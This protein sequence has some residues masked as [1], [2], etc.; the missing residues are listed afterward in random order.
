MPQAATL[1]ADATAAVLPFAPLMEAIAEVVQEVEAGRVTVPER[2]AHPLPGGG[3]LL[4]MPAADSRLLVVKVV[5][6]MPENRERGLPTIQGDFLV[7]DVRT[8]AALLTLD[9]ATVTNRRTAALTLLG[10]RAVGVTAA[11]SVL[12]IGAGPQARAHAEAFMEVLGV[13]RFLVASRRPGSAEKLAAELRAAGVDASRAPA[14]RAA[15]HD[16]DLVLAATTSAMPVVPDEVPD[17]VFVAAVGAFRRGMAEL[18]AALLRRR[19]VVVDTME[20]ARTEAGDLIAAAEAGAWEW[21]GAVSLASLLAPDAP[22]PTRPRLFKSVGHAAF[23]LA[24]AR[25]AVRQGGSPD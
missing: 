15:V 3:R 8:G 4:L 6:V 22:A 13:Q 20:G 18:P 12:L 11:A 14:V 17:G 23:D 1:D 5:T 24:A 21:A 9:A 7:K 25:V 19:E 10:A 2:A 16:V